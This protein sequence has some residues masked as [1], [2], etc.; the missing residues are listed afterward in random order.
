ML[1]GIG[2]ADVLEHVT[3]SRFVPFLLHCFLPLAI[4]SASR[5][6]C[7]SNAMSRRGVC[8]PLYDFFWNA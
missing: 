1:F 4:C 8:R 2:H 7:R 3:A 5:N 6:R